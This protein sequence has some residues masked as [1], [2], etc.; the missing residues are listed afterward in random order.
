MFEMNFMNN[1]HD[2]VF[3]CPKCKNATL[4]PVNGN[5]DVLGL[6]YHDLCICDECGAELWSEPQYD[7]TVK[8]VDI[9]DTA[10]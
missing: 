8:F 4:R 3:V 2:T 9:S 1:I 10:E 6:G 7:Y 5:R